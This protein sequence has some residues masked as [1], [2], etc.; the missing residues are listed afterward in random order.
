MNTTSHDHVRPLCDAHPCTR[1]GMVGV[2]G[3][4]LCMPH[5]T[6]ALEQ[7]RSLWRRIVDMFIET[8]GVM[9]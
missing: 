2:D 5:Y 9:L 8:T 6:E 7:R 4:W 1:P 3:V